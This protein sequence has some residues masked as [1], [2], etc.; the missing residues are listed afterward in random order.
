MA[1]LYLGFDFCPRL[2]GCVNEDNQNR[3][4]FFIP[5]YQRNH[6]KRRTHLTLTIFQILVYIVARTHNDRAACEPHGSE[7]S[8]ELLT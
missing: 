2:R 1:Q 7:N 3:A 5:K 4:L 6:T 8:L